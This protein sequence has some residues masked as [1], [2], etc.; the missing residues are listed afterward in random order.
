MKFALF[1]SFFEKPLNYS[2]LLK[3][4]DLYDLR[5]SYVMKLSGGQ[6]Q[7]LSVILACIPNPKIIFLDE[8]TTGLDPK[9]RR[10]M[11]HLV[12]SLRDEGKTIFLTTHYMEEA[13]F[14]C[15][16]VAIVDRGKIVDLDTPEGLIRKS[17]IEEMVSFEADNIDQEKLSTI[18]GVSNFSVKDE[19]VLLYGKGEDLLKSVVDFLY[20]NK[21]RFRN[22]KTKRPNLEDTFLKLTGREYKEGQNENSN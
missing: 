15:D 22:L 8:I 12:K 1:S 13:E 20:F 18:K 19:L 7:R 11:W 2:D 4:F 6:R 5:K 9:S 17:G 10:D 3:R 14:L 16:R 21:V